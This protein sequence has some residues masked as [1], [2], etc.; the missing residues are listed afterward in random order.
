MIKTRHRPIRAV[1][2][3]I[4]EY[5]MKIFED[6]VACIE[7]GSCEGKCPN[8]LDIPRLIVLF[9]EYV[10]TGDEAKTVSAMKEIPEENQPTKCIGCGTCQFACPEPIEIWKTMGK[11]ANL[12][13]G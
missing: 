12:L 9:N 10:E 11:L 8:G 6:K 5:D 7:C 2:G 13:R 4:K 3:F 1:S